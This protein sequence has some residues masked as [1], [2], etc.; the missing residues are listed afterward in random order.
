KISASQGAKAA[1]RHSYV[2]A[3]GRNGTPF[4]ASGVYLW[5]GQGLPPALAATGAVAQPREFN[6]TEH[7][8]AVV[9]SF[10][11][12]VL[13]ALEAHRHPGYLKGVAVDWLEFQASGRHVFEAHL[14]PVS[15][16]L[17]LQDRPDLGAFVSACEC[18]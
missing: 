12:S 9:E 10:D 6:V 2:G 1:M 5:R 14:Q 18:L 11:H 13:V 7:R 16:G 8:V 17:D 3:F 15:L 4:D